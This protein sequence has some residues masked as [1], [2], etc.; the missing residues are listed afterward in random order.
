MRWPWGRPADGACARPV[1]IA[2]ERTVARCRPGRPPT[3]APTRQ[4]PG[5]AAS[6][7]VGTACGV[8]R[9]P[10]S[11]FRYVRDTGAG[12]GVGRERD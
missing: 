11:A 9:T 4:P 2:L 8:G 5:R 3:P 10:M 7:D 1:R 6:A 12:R